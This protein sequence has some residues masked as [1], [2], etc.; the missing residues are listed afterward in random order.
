MWA[1][2]LKAVASLPAGDG[3]GVGTLRGAAVESGDEKAPV[4]HEPFDHGSRRGLQVWEEGSFGLFPI[5]I[6]GRVVLGPKSPLLVF[7]LEFRNLLAHKSP[8][9]CDSYP[10]QK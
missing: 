2:L 9:P 1:D 7:R 6:F 4:G 10:G 8:S 5:Q 3:Q